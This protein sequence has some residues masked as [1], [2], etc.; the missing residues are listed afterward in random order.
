[1]EVASPLPF[2]RVQT[3][4]KRR[5]ACSPIVDT[6][7]LGMEVAVDDF[8]MVEDN[9][10]F[11]KSVKRRRFAPNDGFDNTSSTFSANNGFSSFQI[12]PFTGGTL[13]S[14]A[15]ST[16]K[17]QRHGDS[18]ES[19]DQKISHFQ[20]ITEQQGSEI[21]QLKAEKVEVESSLSNLKIDHVK[22]LQENKI[23]KRAVTI[24]QERQNQAI[25]EINNAQRYKAHAD[26]QIKK[27]EQAVLTLRYHLQT[28]QS[29]GGN[30]FMNFGP[31]P[32]DVF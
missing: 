22:V 7:R 11:G 25:A 16:L 30:N 21:L 29:C 31:R 18:D 28:Q 8:S 1:M 12:S 13:S 23:L 6:H 19:S 3:G 32:P 26:D 24:Q 15:G 14:P 9:S 2:G 27:L 17:R 5:F 4:A 10:C 20:Q